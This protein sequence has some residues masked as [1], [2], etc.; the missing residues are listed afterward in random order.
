MTDKT[1]LK[2]FIDN[3]DHFTRTPNNGHVIIHPNLPNSFIELTGEFVDE[4]KKDLTTK[5]L[6]AD[7]ELD[8]LSPIERFAIMMLVDAY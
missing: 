7:C 5:I 1:T 8:T 4:L 2:E 6:M 3:F